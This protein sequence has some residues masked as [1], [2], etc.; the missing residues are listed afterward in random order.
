[1]ENPRYLAAYGHALVR[2]GYPIVPIVPGS[3]RPPGEGWQN[4]RSTEALVDTWLS[5]GQAEAGIGILAATAPGVDL[6]I[7]DIDLAR[8][9]QAFVLETVG[10]APVRIGDWPK[11]LLQYRTGAPFHKV[12]S[13][14]WL[15]PDG[16]RCKVEI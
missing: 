9:M 8:E 15:D 14:V 13:R 11:R 1:M 6:D 12:Q 3:K 5:N 16:D 4:T 10:T 7:H 2:N